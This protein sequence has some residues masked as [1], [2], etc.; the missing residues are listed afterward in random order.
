MAMWT[1]QQESAASHVIKAFGWDKET[2]HNLGLLL[3]VLFRYYAQR[4][5]AETDVS[6]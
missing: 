3:W 2:T 6:P 1:P 5:A 4:A